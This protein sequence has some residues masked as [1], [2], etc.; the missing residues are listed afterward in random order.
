MTALLALCGCG[1]EQEPLTVTPASLSLR[2]EDKAQ[3]TTNAGSPTYR[4]EDEFYAT[5]DAVG[6]VTAGKVG[7]TKVVVSAEN[8]VVEVPVTVIPSYDLYPDL[9]VFIGAT[10]SQVSSKFGTGYTENT[11][12]DGGVTW[13]YIGYNKYSS[14]GF[15][16]IGGKVAQVIAAVPTTYAGML[17]D[18]LKERYSV[19]GMLNDYFFLLNHDRS[20]IVTLTVYSLKQ[21]AVLYDTYDATRSVGHDAGVSLFGDVFMD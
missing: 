20:V 21:L 1:K 12:S 6:L 10:P 2:Y 9:D 18:H 3:L 19:A 16:F 4:T 15:H 5:V 8:G 7:K 13:N 11:G 17:A 14:I